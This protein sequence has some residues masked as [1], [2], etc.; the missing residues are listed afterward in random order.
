MTDSSLFREALGSPL[1]GGHFVYS[2]HGRSL[3]A[4]VRYC[5]VLRSRQAPLVAIAD[6]AGQCGTAVCQRVIEARGDFGYDAARDEIGP[7]KASWTP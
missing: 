4:T 6:N 3:F 7:L 5:I 2:A 1:N